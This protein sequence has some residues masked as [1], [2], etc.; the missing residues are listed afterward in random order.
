MPLK[1]YED[2]KAF[3]LFILDVG[4]LSALSKLPARTLIEGD[5]I[6]TEFNGALA[7]QYVLQ[8]LKT[9]DDMEIAY[10]ISKSG[11]A[12][13]DFII[14]TD[15][16]ICLLYTSNSSGKRLSWR[17]CRNYKQKRNRCDIRSKK[18]LA[19]NGA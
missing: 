19:A 8:Q 18:L 3:K 6:F 5:R 17:S 14:Q 10:W 12:E 11:N 15:G 13:L 2:T 16:Y 1:A 9:L 7:E 4:L